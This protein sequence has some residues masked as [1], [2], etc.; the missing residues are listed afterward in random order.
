MAIAHPRT[1]RSI[2]RRQRGKTEPNLPGAHMQPRL[3][4]NRNLAQ[5]RFAKFGALFRNRK[6]PPL[7]VANSQ[8]RGVRVDKV[9]DL[10]TAV[11]QDGRLVFAV[12]QLAVVD[13][14]PG[15]DAVA[16]RF[17]LEFLELGERD[18]VDVGETGIL[19]QVRGLV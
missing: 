5:R 8:A 14:Q 12:H 3:V 11:G 10:P 18:G 6:P 4:A 7:K 15:G 13:E 16:E 2:R 9:A 19:E 1:P 17:G